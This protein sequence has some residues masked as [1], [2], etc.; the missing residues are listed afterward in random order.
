[1]GRNE[2]VWVSRTREFQQPGVPCTRAQ[3][4]ELSQVF[5]GRKGSVVPAVRGSMA[6]GLGEDGQWDLYLSATVL[7]ARYRKY[8][9]KAMAGSR[10][11]RQ[12]VRDAG[13]E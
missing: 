6:V 12:E 13:P 3:G 11:T 8:I 10:K 2:E 4:Q 9:Q 5:S 7:C 1:M